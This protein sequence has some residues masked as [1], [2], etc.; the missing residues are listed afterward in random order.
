MP[1]IHLVD[2]LVYLVVLGLFVQFAPDVLSESFGVSLL[3]AILLKLVMELVVAAKTRVVRR[4]RSA[5]TPRVKVT[6]SVTLVLV[7]AGSKFV[8]LWL[9]DVIFGDAVYLGGFLS[10]TLL[11]LT[12]MA[13]R[14]IVRRV[15]R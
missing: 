11:V 15:V 13:A 10:V 14:A 6:A 4:I 1:A 12:L 2:V 7:A 5:E 3:T 9:T 8:I